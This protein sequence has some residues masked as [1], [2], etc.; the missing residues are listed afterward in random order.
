[1]F[2]SR[3]PDHQ[4]ARRSAISISDS[5]TIQLRDR[6][7][8]DHDGTRSLIFRKAR[9]VLITPSRLAEPRLG[10]QRIVDLSR[11]ASGFPSATLGRG[12]P[13]SLAGAGRPDGC[14]DSHGAAQVHPFTAER[15]VRRAAR[16]RTEFISTGDLAV[17]SV[18]A[19]LAGSRCLRHRRRTTEG[20][21][22]KGAHGPGCRAPPSRGHP[23]H[24]PLGSVRIIGVAPAAAASKLSTTIMRPSLA[25]E[26]IG[27]LALLG[28]L[29]REWRRHAHHLIATTFRTARLA[30]SMLGHGFD[31]LESLL[32]LIAAIDVGWHIA[33][34]FASR[35]DIREYMAPEPAGETTVQPPQP[36][37][38]EGAEPPGRRPQPARYRTPALPPDGA[39]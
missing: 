27:D 22:L 6:C 29:R 39:S 36:V 9:G 38:R 20:S 26:R 32:A 24:R 10:P 30:R 25:S 3:R 37:A 21:P 28:G 7:G 35:F 15:G 33:P 2:E 13:R 12:R 23:L 18:L 5:A 8:R 17:R 11:Q 14:A 31:A 4:N 34:P 19:E 1:V 16:A